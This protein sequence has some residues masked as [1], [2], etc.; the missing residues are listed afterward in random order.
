MLMQNNSGI[1]PVGHRILIKPVKTE[2]TTE[3]GIVIETDVSADR[4]Q[5]AQVRG[6]VVEIGSTAYSDQ[7]EPWCKVGDVVT[8]GK[9]SGLI[10]KGKDTLDNE[11]YRVV[12]DLD[13]VCIHKEE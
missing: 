5:L 2:K 10:Y 6:T 4:A 13:V 1:I 8:F 3:S 9:Y 11:E 12:N 7:P